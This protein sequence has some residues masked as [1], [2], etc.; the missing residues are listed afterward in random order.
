MSSSLQRILFFACVLA[1]IVHG[2]PLPLQDA[3]VKLQGVNVTL[4]NINE[5]FAADASVSIS[6]ENEDPLLTVSTSTGTFAGAFNATS[7]VYHW[8][9][10]P[11]AADTGDTNRFQPPRQRSVSDT[12][13]PQDATKYG[14]TCPQYLSSGSKMAGGF[15]GIVVDPNQG[16]DCLSA[17][18][19]VGKNVRNGTDIGAGAPVMLFLYG[20]SFTCA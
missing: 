19:W 11:Y 12:D 18:V 13:T 8:L 2:H 14:F 4:S 5:G 6:S 10:M 15:A 16:E 7:G 20:G 3:T 1:T 9:G 17:N